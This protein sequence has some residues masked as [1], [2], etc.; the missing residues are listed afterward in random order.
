MTERI[1]IW[2]L[3][4]DSDCLPNHIGVSSANHTYWPR[5]SGA[6]KEMIAH[7]TASA[8]LKR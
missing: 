5:R 6:L 4:H 7:Q 3:E 1:G 8:V 2:W